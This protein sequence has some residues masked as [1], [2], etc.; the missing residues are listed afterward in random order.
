MKQ[1]D[2]L[3]DNEGNTLTLEFVDG[4]ETE[5]SYIVWVN[6]TY[7]DETRQMCYER[8]KGQKSWS[9]LDGDNEFELSP[10][11]Q[12]MWHDSY[13]DTLL[14]CLYNQCSWK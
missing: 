14:D 1:Y 2:N 10:D 3:H 12:R 5:D 13:G 8:L 7:H 4:Q 6:Q 11:I 9:F